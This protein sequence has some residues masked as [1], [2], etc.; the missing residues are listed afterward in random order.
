MLVGALWWKLLGELPD[1]GL[2]LSG[3]DHY[4]DGPLTGKCVSLEEA[5]FSGILEKERCG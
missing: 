5:L 3:N 2:N 4:L 1:E